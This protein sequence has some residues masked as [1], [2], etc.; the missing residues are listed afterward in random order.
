MGT[1]K[2]EGSILKL[3]S[4]V[5]ARSK[6]TE[7]EELV[8]PKTIPTCKAISVRLSKP[9]PTLLHLLIF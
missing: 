1:C 8:F 5:D 6:A 3:L 9:S 7:G 4:K 2:A